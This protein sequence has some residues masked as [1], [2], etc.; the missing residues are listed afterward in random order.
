VKEEG[1]ET[2]LHYHAT[3]LHLGGGGGLHLLAHRDVI[4][5]VTTAIYISVHKQATEPQKNKTAVM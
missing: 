3:A 1:G 2:V 5:T 4:I